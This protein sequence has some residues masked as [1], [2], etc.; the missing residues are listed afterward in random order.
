MDF[1][2]Q[3]VDFVLHIDKHLVELT[4]E[5]GIYIYF[6]LFTIL[7]CETG[8]VVAAILPGDS[9]LFAAGALSSSGNL[10][11]YY[12]MLFIIVGAILGNQSNFYIGRWLG[13]RLSTLNTKWINKEYIERTQKFYEKH[14]GKALI[15]GRFLPIIRTF[16]PLVAGIGKMNAGKFLIYNIVGALV[17]VIPLTVLGYWFGNIP[18]VKNNFSIV[19]LII[20]VVSA[21]PLYIGLWN[22][23][24]LL[25]KV[26]DFE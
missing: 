2:R 6:I 7:F 11:L 1:F 20:I 21:M 25:S 12:T 3:L 8:L 17:W 14:G 10:N 24:K 23:K 19:I 5:Y 13:P 18:F 9:L 4:T 26:K 22:R 16:V 15:I